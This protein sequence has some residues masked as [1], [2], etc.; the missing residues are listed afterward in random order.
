M[1]T[2]RILVIIKICDIDNPLISDVCSRSCFILS[3][4][5]KL[6]P[7]RTKPN[8]HREEWSECT[9]KH[10]P[11][12]TCDVKNKSETKHNFGKLDDVKHVLQKDWQVSFSIIYFNICLHCRSKRVGIESKVNFEIPL[13]FLDQGIHFFRLIS[14]ST[15]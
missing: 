12:T 11:L 7:V 6:W 4:S 15:I 5:S 9:K 2:I 10:T 14:V 8:K 3:V 13:I 1:S